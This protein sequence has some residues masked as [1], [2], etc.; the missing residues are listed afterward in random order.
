MQKKIIVQLSDL[1]IKAPGVLSYGRV[2]TA[3]YLRDAVDAVLR[4]PQA[5]DAIL[6]SGDLVDGGQDEEYAHLM[7]L[8]EPLRCPLYAL[9]GNH[10]ERAALRR[11]FNGPAHA[12]LAAPQP[13][14][15]IQYAV[16]LGGLRLVVLDTVVPWKGHGTLCPVR[17]A[18]LARTL[19][20][21]TRT[22]TIVAMHHPPF[23]TQIALM[24]S[25]GITQ[26]RE[27][28]LRLIDEHPNVERIVC[29]HLHRPIQTRVANTLAMTAPSVAHQ[30]ALDL[31]PDSK[32]A[33]IMEP[34]AFLVHSW[35]PRM[36]LV[37]HQAY[38]GSFDGP[39]PFS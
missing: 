30:V 33:F 32:G 31:D 16:N 7:T 15:F 36:G 5:P 38:I 14:A 25:L 2:D 1:H 39:Y 17:L 3:K 9:P 20:E 4:L 29:G 24:D 28:F 35:V 23:D 22:P 10:D 6:L 34:P 13:D 12:Y 27:E 11:A 37:T 18:W 21:D 26:G 19:N 8:L